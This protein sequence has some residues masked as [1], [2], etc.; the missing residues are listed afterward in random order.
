MRLL[1]Y[2]AV[3]LVLS[4]LAY[5]QSFGPK[6]I[7]QLPAATT[8]LTGT[9]QIPLQQNGNT[10]Q[11]TINNI[12]GSP[13]GSDTQLQFNNN[14]TF[15]GLSIGAG[16]NVVGGALI[17]TSTGG[18][19]PS[20]AQYA[21]QYNSGTGSFAGLSTETDAAYKA[22]NAVMNGLAF[23]PR[24]PTYGAVCGGF[25][26]FTG[27]GSTKT[28]NYTIPF[29]GANSTD[30]S[31]FMVFYEPTSGGGTATILNASQFTVTGVNSGT[32][33]TITLATAPPASNYLFVVHD[34]SAGLVAASTAAVAKGGFVRVPNGCTIYG[35]Q[36]AGTQ[37]ADNAQ[38]IGQG[39]SPNYGGYTDGTLKP[40][41]YVLAPTGLAPAAGINITG[42][43]KQFFEG[44]EITGKIPGYSLQFQTVPV[45]IGSIGSSGAGGGGLPGVVAQYMSFTYGK[46]GFGA[47]KSGTSGY[48][49]STVRFSNFSANDAG[50]YGP[51]SDQQIIN[52]LFVNNGGFGSY[53]DSGGMVIGP[54]Q[55]ASGAS[56]AARVV[57][58]RFEFNREGI[59]VKAGEL[60]T[61]DGNEFDSNEG[62]AIDLF[63]SWKN[64]NITGGWVRAS[65]KGPGPGYT[66]NITSGRDAHICINGAGSNLH[67]ANTNFING[68][69]R[70]Y[71]A[72]I[73][74]SEANTPLYFLDVTTTG[75]G[76]ENI[77]ISNANIENSFTG[78]GSY[79][80]DFAIYRNGKPLN[81]KVDANGQ[82]KQ[83][84][85]VKG[86]L[87]S[88]AS[89]LPANSWSGLINFGDIRTAAPS[90]MAVSQIYPYLIGNAMGV[91]PINYPATSFSDDWECDNVN[92]RV[93]PNV[94]PQDTGNP[95]ITWLPS[96]GDPT[97]GGGGADNHRNDTASC[98]LAALTWMA[99]PQSHKIYAQNSTNVVQTGSWS[100]FSSYGGTYGL[101]S[102]T[103]GDSLAFT[104]TTYGGPLYLWYELQGNSGGTFRWTLD[105]TTT[106]SVAVQGNNAFTFPLSSSSQAPAAVRIPVQSSG[107]HTLN[108]ALTSTTT[109]GNPVTIL[110]V[111]TP[112]GKSYARGVPTV[113]LGGQIYE[114]NDALASTTSAYNQ[115]QRSQAEQLHADGLNVNFVDVRNYITTV[116]DMI[117]S[118]LSGN[119]VAPN[120][121]GQKHIADAFL[122]AMQP[123]ANN[124]NAV[125]PRDFGAAC[126][127][128]LFTDTF[129][130][131]GNPSHIVST[132]TGSSE[133]SIGNYT[134]QPGVARQG[135]GGGDVGK[136]ISISN[137]SFP[138]GKTT[139]IASVNTSTN[140]A[141]L[142]N[143]VAETT[144]P[145]GPSNGTAVMGGYPLN[146]ND[147][148][149]AVD[150][151]QF[152]RAASQAAVAVG[153]VGNAYIS[154]SGGGRVALPTN[155]LVRN[156]VP[157]N[158]SQ[159][160]GNM[161]GV[162]YIA[163]NNPGV[164]ATTLYIN[165]S[166]FAGDAI[167]GI[168]LE[169]TKGVR[170]RDIK[171][172]T[173]VF[174]Y[175]TQGMTLACIRTGASGNLGTEDALVEHNSIST[176]PVG[177]GVPLGLSQSVGFTATIS[178]TTMEVSSIDTTNIQAAYADK[179][180]VHYANNLDTKADWLA[181]GRTISGPG[182]TT[183]TKITSAPIKGGVGTYTIS[184]SLNVSSTS[185]VSP[186]QQTTFTGTARNNLFGTNGIG[187]NGPATDFTAE[188]NVFG[189]NY[190]F[191]F[192]MG[193]DVGTSFGNGANRINLG[194]FEGG[195]IADF[196]C[197]GCLQTQV[198]GV[199]FQFS[200]C[201]IW[202]RNAWSRLQIT[203]GMSEGSACG[204]KMG[205]VTDYSHILLGGSGSN[206]NITGMQFNSSCF[207][208]PCAAT[209][210]YLFQTA[211][212][213]TVDFISLDGGDART[214]GSTYPY[215]WNGNTPVHFRVNTGSLPA[216]D[217]FV[218][219]SFTGLTLTS[220]TGGDK[221]GS[222]I[223]TTTTTGGTFTL[224]GLFASA[225]G[226]N[227]TGGNSTQGTSFAMNNTTS[228]SCSLGVTTTNGDNVWWMARPR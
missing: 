179:G 123:K 47:P 78:N 52:N 185:L 165:S 40:T 124:M 203:G 144:L 189:Y 219:P 68:Y 137:T 55:S 140:K 162:P 154:S 111:G 133:I 141:T 35:S 72:Q 99:I 74:S 158:G 103:S 139:Y 142:G 122:G 127:A 90:Y 91:A 134:F 174:P 44:F 92:E 178:G 167:V 208:S 180:A 209:T 87:S 32:G 214:Y 117:A 182:V 79:V 211:T 75:S 196:V 51:L 89:G 104:T 59:V 17:S 38:L 108:V 1:K 186:R 56:G 46:V 132:T 50:I 16:L 37:L 110:G 64:L 61:F 128:Q 170:I 14:G 60:I 77:S 11:T 76:V 136:L 70:G 97:Y 69:N 181:L 105:S 221:S 115:D 82:A 67:I 177:Y 125:D 65:G 49:F 48:I 7:D 121:T 171:I 15:G 161:A 94:N 197:D 169:G 80:R 54:Q 114:Y 10:K 207:A 28:F 30:N 145:V 164:S 20:G 88:Q 148:S 29:R 53:G 191:G 129:I 172:T 36:A 73:G 227:C 173:P 206:L 195:Q 9:E 200:G 34:D 126:N 212:G 27:D 45:L 135:G 93:F 152:I 43:T 63:S 102:T 98:R 220:T 183:G 175:L 188:S 101:T 226:Y 26:I 12:M 3:F 39:F 130:D 157:A 19:S 143:W 58:N 21:L 194:R 41:M 112:P 218:I 31:G 106:G 96:P 57:A 113:Y 163:Q 62:C 5:A 215:K 2:L 168:D 204:L 160:V 86:K 147:P 205:A 107:G 222:A 22:H 228:T 131:G 109:L 6:R 84:D 100:N 202:T 153:G 198:N 33:G 193:P 120:A 25:N 187:L 119:P 166:G 210:K 24:D 8:P 23:D 149:T 66:G 151:T 213:S 83:G 116:S 138:P 217:S 159:I 18:A 155:C 81:M 223:T 201:A 150:D 192:Y 95:V 85:L 4:T 184:N 42:K 156:L 71:T 190:S 176:C 146:P 224:G 199:Q 118:G 225:N 216:W 13:G